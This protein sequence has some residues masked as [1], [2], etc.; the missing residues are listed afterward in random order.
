MW[1]RH[2]GECS[3]A[4]KVYPRYWMSLVLAWGIGASPWFA[5]W[6][7]DPGLGSSRGWH[8]D[9]RLFGARASRAWNVLCRSDGLAGHP[10]TCPIAQ[11]AH[12]PGIYFDARAPGQV[13]A[14]WPCQ[15]AP[16]SPGAYGRASSSPRETTAGDISHS[17]CYRSPHTW[18]VARGRHFFWHCFFRALSF[19]EPYGVPLWQQLCSNIFLLSQL[20][21]RFI[22]LDQTVRSRNPARTQWRVRIATSLGASR[23][24]IPKPDDAVAMLKRRTT[25]F[26]RGQER[27][28]PALTGRSYLLHR[29]LT[30]GSWRNPSASGAVRSRAWPTV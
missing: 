22:D 7:A 8:N 15:A 20:L 2:P 14:I 21:F 13:A 10:L 17:P 4:I 9:V 11:K 24:K 12:R 28:A 29:R 3:T 30:G 5:A 26:V 19:C 6:I 18:R 1:T 27:T 23:R 16:P 25:F